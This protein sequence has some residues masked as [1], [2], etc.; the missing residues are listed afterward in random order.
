MGQVYIKNAY[1]VTMND[2]GTVYKNGGVLTEDDRIIAVGPVDPALVKPGAE[3]VNGRGKYVLPGLVNT[4]RAH[5]ATT[6]PRPGRRRQPA[7]L[8]ARAHLAL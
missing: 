6:G 7:H 3:V 2:Q 1:V 5:L 8:A 4:P